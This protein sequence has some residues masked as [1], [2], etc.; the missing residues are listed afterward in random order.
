[1]DDTCWLCTVGSFTL[2]RCAALNR[3]LALGI[4]L[5]RYK[6][7]SE[8]EESLLVSRE[9]RYKLEINI[10][11]TAKNMNKHALR[12]SNTHHISQ[13][14]ECWKE[15]YLQFESVPIYHTF[16]WRGTPAKYIG[17]LS[18]PSNGRYLRSSA[19]ICV[20][21]TGVISLGWSC[22]ST[23]TSNSFMRLEHLLFS[24][25]HT[26]TQTHKRTQQVLVVRYFGLSALVGIGS[27]HAMSYPRRSSEVIS[28]R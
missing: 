12:N 4:S 9:E 8:E 15:W 26:H 25:S 28:K 18:S 27:T 20:P 6:L 14:I 2:A 3:W 17:W 16:L 1:M 19:N 11:T 21:T 7:F 5:V 13:A 24:L 23:E 22:L 10:G